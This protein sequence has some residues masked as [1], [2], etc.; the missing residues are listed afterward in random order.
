MGDAMGKGPG[1]SGPRAR[2]DEEWT[3]DDVRR[4][5]LFGIE[6]GQYAGVLGSGNGGHYLSR[7]RSRRRR[8]RAGRGI[9]CRRR[10]RGGLAG[11]PRRSILLVPRNFRPRRRRVAPRRPGRRLF[12]EKGR[13]TGEP[14]ELRILEEANRAVHAVEPGLADDLLASK[15]RDGLRDERGRGRPDVLERNRVEKRQLRPEAAE[16]ALV[17]LRD[18]A[19]LRAYLENF[20]QDLGQ[21]D[22]ASHGAGGRG[23]CRRLGPVREVLDPV[24]H[25][26]R[27]GL[28]AHRAEAP[29][30]PGLVRRQADLAAPVAVQV[31]LAFLGKEL[32]GAAVPFTGLQGPAKG[33][34]V[35]VG[36]EHAHL[37]PELLRRVGVRVGYEPEA[38]EGRDPPVHRRVGG[39][40]GL[41][42]E[43]VLREIPV[44]VVDGVEPRL[45]AEGG[46]PW[47]PDVGGYEIGARVRLEGDF[48]EMP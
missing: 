18:P 38:I 32:D 46:E 14:P 7:A 19:A 22:E 25:P 41:H 10:R 42:R 43:D 39:E 31:V 44:A 15:A 2:D 33:E 21:R 6:P 12:S 1:L 37:A 30:P 23:G 29:V 26:D 28:A 34:V 5:A 20:G 13:S 45:R 8:G 36:V 35:E 48:E 17:V 4:A 9:Q 27:Q 3:R 11:R 40:A 16:K 47:G 24:H